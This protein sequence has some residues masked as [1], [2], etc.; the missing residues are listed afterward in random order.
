MRRRRVGVYFDHWLQQVA[1]DQGIY[2]YPFCKLAFRVHSVHNLVCCA[3]TIFYMSVYFRSK[4][5]ILASKSAEKTCKVVSLGALDGIAS[6]EC[7]RIDTSG[8]L[9][10]VK[11]NGV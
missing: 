4:M 8:C 6:L 11:L 1:V 9:L 2:L 10:R 5:Q 7:R 3:V